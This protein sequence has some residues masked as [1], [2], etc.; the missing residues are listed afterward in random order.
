MSYIG[1]VFTFVFGGNVLFRYGAGT[2]SSST[3]TRAG[4]GGWPAFLTL[5]SVSL[6]SAALHSTIMRY[7]LYPLGLEALEPLSYVLVVVTLLYSLASVLAAGSGPFAEAGR[8]A[9]EQVHSC[10]V[11]A[12]SLS[13]ARGGFT[14]AEAAAAGFAAAAGWWC[15]VVLLDRI[16]RRLEME[17]VPPA[18]KGA[19]LRFLSAGLMAMAVSGIDQI[20]V[21]RIA[22]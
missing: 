8:I 2:C 7:V 4:G 5:G 21:S 14:M 20:L 3:E 11:Y 9:K 18:L 22:G 16:L 12:A 13:A 6:L 17:D 10:V 19:P 15:A 1:I